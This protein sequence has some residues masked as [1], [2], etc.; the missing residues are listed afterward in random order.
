MAGDRL[1]LF[2][3][4]WPC[5]EDRA[6]LAAA[7]RRALAD[8]SGRLVPPENHHLTLAFLGAVESAR[9]AAVRAVGAEVA[10]RPVAELPIPI[11]L[12]ALEHFRR[13]QVLAATASRPPAAAGELAE[14]LKQAL[15]Q[16]GFSPDLK[17]FRAHVTLVRKV[18]RVSADL[19]M[20]ST[21]WSFAEL[22]LVS[23]RTETSGSLYS[24][25]DR[26]ALCGART[27]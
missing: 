18:S 3:A 25:L 1:R 27:R 6:R 23:S 22:V 14:H 5:D 10:S 16:A 24:V 9:L 19:S 13:A 17:P 12:D 21:L 8:A 15:T 26:W 20:E 2:F 4:F 7:T 11:T